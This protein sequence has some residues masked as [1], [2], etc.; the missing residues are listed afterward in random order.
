[1][2]QDKQQRAAKSAHQR[3]KEQSFCHDHF[4]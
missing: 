4:H 3:E 1:M 2:I